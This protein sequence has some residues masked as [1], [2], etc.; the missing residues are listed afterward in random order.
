MTTKTFVFAGAS[1]KIAIE[2]AKQ[3][4]QQGHKIIG[5]STKAENPVYDEF[6]SIGQYDFDR[7]PSVAEPIDGLVYFPGTINLKPFHRLA[8]KD[9]MNDYQINSLGAVAFTQAYLANLKKRE[10]AAIIYLSTV[11]VA[12]GMPFHASVAMAKAALEGLTKALAAELAPAI[13]VNCIA[14]SLTETP[15]AEKFLNTPEKTAVSKK[16]NPLR[17]IGEASDLANAIAFLLSDKA[18][19]VTGQTLAVDGGMSNLKL[20]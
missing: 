14:P 11:A 16:R 13:R 9:F 5:I 2:T 17:K 8:Q 20:L 10:H 18:A 19:W 3:L 12:V 7:F 15:L 4:K 6:H 1:S